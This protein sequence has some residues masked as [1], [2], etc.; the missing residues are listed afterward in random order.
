M[1]TYIKTYDL[2]KVWPPAATLQFCMKN[3]FS[4]GLKSD[5]YNDSSVI[6]QQLEECLKNDE[7]YLILAHSDG[8]YT[9]WGMAY[10]KDAARRSKGFQCY[11]MPRQRRK[12]IGT[13]LLEKACS[14]VGRVEVYDHATSNKFFKANGITRG[15]AITGNRLKK[16]V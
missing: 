16:K 7:G 9:G 4:R 2:S 13:L 5:E 15:E 1:K 11:V 10:K 8:K 3:N 12:G 6:K 14:L